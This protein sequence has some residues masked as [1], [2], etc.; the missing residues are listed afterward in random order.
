MS[1]KLKTFYMKTRTNYVFAKW[2]GLIRKPLRN[3][4]STKRIKFSKETRDI[5]CL[6]TGKRLIW[7]VV[8]ISCPRPGK[9]LTITLNK[10]NL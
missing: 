1:T 2:K 8:Q 7:T 4:M 6:E 3:F 9:S 5:S 10:F